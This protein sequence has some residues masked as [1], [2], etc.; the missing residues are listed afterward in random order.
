LR[1]P[2]EAVHGDQYIAEGVYAQKAI[3][4]IG[5]PDQGRNG[6]PLQ[7]S[8]ERVVTM[9]WGNLPFD[10]IDAQ[11]AVLRARMKRYPARPVFL[12]ARIAP[13]TST[14]SG[15]ASVYRKMPRNHFA[16]KGE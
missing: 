6:Y 10:A 9:A 7:S 14:E 13:V 5:D 4:E 2:V 11:A 15:A 1:T 16:M 8:C 12:V 3:E